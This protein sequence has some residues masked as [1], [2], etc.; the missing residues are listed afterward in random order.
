[1]AA[2]KENITIKEI[3]KRAG[4][5]VSTVSR[6]MS[7]KKTAIPISEKTRE[8]VMQVCNELKFLP[9]V[10]YTRLQERRSHTI[11]F[12]VPRTHEDSP[13]PIFL[14]DNI[15]RALSEME[16][17]FASNG[18]SILVQTVDADYEK[19]K[20]HLR[21]L[22]NNSVDGLLIW[23]A[24]RETVLIRELME[25]LRPSI[26]VG[27]TVPEKA[28]MIVP[29]NFQGAYDMTRRLI[30]LGH[31]KI[32]YING[33]MGEI[34]D[35]LREEGYR[36]ALDDA[37]LEPFVEIGNYRLESGCHVARKLLTN[38]SGVTA[39]FAAG[40]FMAIG[41]MQEAARQGVSVPA[42]LSIAGFDGSIAGSLTT[43]A[44]TTAN[45]PMKEIGRLS[46]EKIIAMIENDETGP[47]EEVFDLKI[48]VEI[49]ERGSTAAA[50]R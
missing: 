23:D 49:V 38:G 45:L 3:A 20:H 35:R 26:C 15:G 33:G 36:K 6:V 8:K 32:A 25:E 30:E 47:Y 9:D 7:G 1:M 14:D 12:L 43:P 29:D 22:R 19:E 13:H 17:V 44:L 31:R 50:A 2:D 10:N 39:I 27:L 41:A 40:D 18:Y 46:A 42:E 4:V 5:S 37:D 16:L 21:I 11:A 48:P 34:T 28:H 24:F